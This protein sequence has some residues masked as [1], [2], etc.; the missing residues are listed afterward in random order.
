MKIEV[1][2][3]VYKI[4]PVYDLYAADENGNIMNIV[5]KVPTKGNKMHDG[6]MKFNVRKHG[7][8][9]SKNYRVHR[10]IWECFNGLI[11]DD[12]VIDHINNIKDDNRLCNLQ[13]LTP[14][15][16]S[17]KSAENRDH[18]FA[19]KNF[20]NP[21]CLK[22]INIVTNEAIYFNS[23]YATSQHLG[24]SHGNINE[25]CKN[26]K[27][28]KTGISKK[29][30]ERYRFEYVKK[31]DMPD[32]YLKSANIRPKRVSEEEKQRRKAV[33]LNKL[34][35]CKCGNFYKHQYRNVH[36][37]YCKSE[38]NIDKIMENIKINEYAIKRISNKINDKYENQA[39]NN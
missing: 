4:H 1:K 6:Y 32:N 3:C 33:R 26:G 2:N 13:L 12:K 35:V 8:K 20:Y 9:N 37:R 39:R 5:K 36:K 31:E 29:N 30:G 18:S 7:E 22:A 34:F 38:S 27:Y 24:I 14:S 17:K 15:E 25:I 11:L 16:N 19:A 21:K 10:L 28:R 23:I